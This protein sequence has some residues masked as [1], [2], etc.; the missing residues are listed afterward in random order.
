M[1]NITPSFFPFLVDPAR[2]DLDDFA[3]GAADF[4]LVDSD[5]L[6]DLGFRATAAFC[7]ERGTAAVGVT[8]FEGPAFPVG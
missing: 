3:V 6:D 1:F 7:L 5:G 2:Y 8:A 4:E